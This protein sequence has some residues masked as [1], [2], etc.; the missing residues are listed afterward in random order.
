M[1]VL[2]ELKEIVNYE[3]LYKIN[4]NGEVFRV[5]KKGV[6]KLKPFIRN[7]YNSVGLSK[8]GVLKLFNIHRLV[9]K[10][11][12]PNP[13]NKPQVNHKNG[14]K[15][16]N[17]VSN[18][19]WC[20][21]SENIKHAIVNKLFSPKPICVYD[22]K[23]RE[24]RRQARLGYKL[25]KE[26]KLKISK[27]LCKKIVSDTGLIFNSLQEASEFEKIPKTTFHRKLNSQQL[28][29]GNLYRYQNENK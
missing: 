4:V 16:D 25:P 21:R 6:K 17:R 12:I 28:I 2:E 10:A 29:N 19:E 24:V 7:G 14:I 1:N 11:F 18:L 20:T 15:T 26:V 22:E 13:E 3:D 27:S 8:K 9:A 23:L 5:T